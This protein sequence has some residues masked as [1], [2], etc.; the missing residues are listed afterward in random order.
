MELLQEL[1]EGINKVLHRLYEVVNKIIQPVSDI[2]FV[3][4]RR[5]RIRKGKN[6]GKRV[7]IENTN[8]RKFDTSPVMRRK[9]YHC[10][11]NC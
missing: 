3:C 8:L 2:L 11:N 1:I 5:T 4:Q 7:P 6:R 10:R 9:I